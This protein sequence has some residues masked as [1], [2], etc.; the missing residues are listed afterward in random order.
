MINRDDSAAK[1]IEI[2]KIRAPES[3]ELLTAADDD[4]F[5]A[6]LEVLLERV[7]DG[8]ESNSKNFDTLK[9]VG[10]TGALAMG[11]QMPGLRV[12]QEANSNGH[13]DITI[14][15]I[16]CSPMRKRIGEAK[17]YGGPEK[18]VKGLHQLLGKYTTGREG[19]GLLIEYI[20]QEN[21][22]GLVKK[23][24][25]HMDKELPYQQQ[26]S[27][28]DLKLKWSFVSRHKHSCGDILGVAHIACNLY[29]GQAPS[30]LPTN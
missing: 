27:T 26:G 15:A 5:D 14:E 25:E 19:R 7:V 24:R 13:V 21:I 29:P 11:L 12:T 30:N 17:V 1:L 20:R 22:T 18:H 8:L 16:H 28:G 6:A 23:L 9:E 4:A 10:L 2:L 3:V